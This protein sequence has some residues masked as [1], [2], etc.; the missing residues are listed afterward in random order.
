MLNDLVD[1]LLDFFNFW[2]DFVVEWV[3]GDFM[4]GIGIFDAVF[5]DDADGVALGVD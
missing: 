2:E 4:V 3:G 1:F 5:F